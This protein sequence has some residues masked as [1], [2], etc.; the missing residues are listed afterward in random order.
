MKKSILLF[1]TLFIVAIATSA[2]SADGSFTTVKT[3]GKLII[4]LDDAFPPMG[5]RDDAGKLVGFDIDTAEEVGKRLGI[6][7]EWQPAA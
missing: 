1:A 7:I 4:G 5:Y 3:A 6:K 2:F